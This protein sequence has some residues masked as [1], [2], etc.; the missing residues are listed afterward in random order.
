MGYPPEPWSLRGRMYVSV[1]ALPAAALPAVPP[2]LAGAVRVLRLGARAFVGAA[3]VDYR[4]GGVLSYRELLA[5]VLMRHGLRPRVTITHIWVDSPESR[6]GGRELWGIPKDLAEFELTDT[7]A[8]ASVGASAEIRSA[9]PLLRLPIGFKC[10][11]VLHGAPKT[12]PVRAS[13]RCGPATVRWHIDAA[14]PLGFL[15]GRKPLLSLVADDFRMTFGVTAAQS[16][17]ASSGPS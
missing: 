15:H 11:Q 7:R 2:E 16:R 8:A 10:T 14:G 4:P 17:T 12:T 13:A 6:D 9:K 5:A 3:W 1:W